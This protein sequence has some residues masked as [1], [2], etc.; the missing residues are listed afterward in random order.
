[1]T[2]RYVVSVDALMHATCYVAR[3]WGEEAGYR[4]EIVGS[5]AKVVVLEVSASDGAR[6]LVAADRWGNTA[7]DTAHEGI[8]HDAILALMGRVGQLSAG[9][10]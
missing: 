3:E 8:D 5:S 9:V 1:M 4:C 6:F 2:G 10:R 7:D